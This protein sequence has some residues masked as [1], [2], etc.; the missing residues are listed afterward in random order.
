MEKS[1]SFKMT[2]YTGNE[3]DTM[4]DSTFFGKTNA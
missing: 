4:A 3:I 2:K 1:P